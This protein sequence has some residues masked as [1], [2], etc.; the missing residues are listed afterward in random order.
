M[1]T[2]TTSGSVTHANIVRPPKYRPIGS[3]ALNDVTSS[4][5]YSGSSKAKFVIEIDASGTPDTFKWQKENG[6]LTSGVSITG[7][8]Q[9]LSD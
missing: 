6:V 3:S 1:N 2:F 5:T 7:S 8:A 4:G 9:T